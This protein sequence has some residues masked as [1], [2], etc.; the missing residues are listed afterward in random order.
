MP[1]LFYLLK[2]L[3]HKK[4]ITFLGQIDQNNIPS[5]GIRQHRQRSVNFPFIDIVFNRRETSFQSRKKIALL[6]LQVHPKSC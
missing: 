5:H 4:I 3:A 1:E 6:T 2:K